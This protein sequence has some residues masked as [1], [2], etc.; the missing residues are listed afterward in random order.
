MK[1]KAN[2]K[3]EAPQDRAV[4]IFFEVIGILILVVEA[5][6][7]IYVLSASFSSSSEYA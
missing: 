1:K 3:K 2:R 5:Y 4:H 6:P 7:L